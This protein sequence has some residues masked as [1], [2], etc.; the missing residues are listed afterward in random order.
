MSEQRANRR[1]RRSR[2][3]NLGT[4]IEKDSGPA[5]KGVEGGLLRPL[6]QSDMLKIDQAAW[7]ILQSVGMSEAP[8]IVVDSVCAAGGFLNDKGRLC[9]SFSLIQDALSGL[10]KSFKLYGQTP[11]RELDLTGTKVHTGTGG[12]APLILDIESRT[13]RETTLK[14]LYDS[15]RLIDGL[16]HIHFFSRTMT[17]RELDT[18]KALDVNTAY[19]SLKG[20]SKHV[21]T[22]ITEA[23]NVQDIA[24]MCYLIAGSK[25]AFIERPFLSVNINHAVPPLRFDAESCRVMAE[26][27]KAGLPVHAN[28][29]SQVG[30][31][32]PVTLAG[33]IAQTMAETLAGMI[34]A[35]LINPEAK[36]VFG[37][38]P[39]IVD[40]RTGAV[41]GGG[42]EQALYM[43]ACSQMAQYYELPNSAIAGATDS[44]IADAQSGYEKCLAVANVAQAG[45]NM[46]TQSCGM[47]ANL[48]GCAL[49][50]FVID[51]DMLGGI[52]RTLEKPDINADTL[53]LDAITEVVN[54]EGHFLGHPE[55]YKRM[56]SDFLYPETADRASIDEWE[57]SGAKNI[58]QKALIVTKQRLSLAWPDHISEEI[59]LMLKARFDLR[60]QS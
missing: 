56:K 35:W 16:E 25:E 20:T 2:S 10:K 36:V 6:T 14:D 47:Q 1:S 17:A 24:E 49:E 40:M 23:E 38:R 48:M 39:M 27:T 19:A 54:G 46:I 30:A 52:L 57:A 13:Y 21:C 34:F 42:G 7:V 43:A 32:C 51:N 33:A 18:V 55:T 50:A 12:A 44:K 22:Q 53:A 60:L 26:A 45:C 4:D 15:A 5:T 41:S 8:S 59:D 29:Y 11:G 58:R 28:V 9:Y 37:G 3:S 31:S